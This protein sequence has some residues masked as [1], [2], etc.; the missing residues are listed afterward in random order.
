MRRG[1][2]MAPRMPAAARWGRWADQLRGRH[3]RV[4]GRYRRLALVLLSRIAP[5]QVTIDRR[6]D[7]LQ[8]GPRIE[9]AIGLF[10]KPESTGQVTGRRGLPT[11]LV[12]PARSRGAHAVARKS[13]A[14][15]EIGDQHSRFEG[16]ARMEASDAMTSTRSPLRRLVRRVQQAADVQDT[17]LRLMPRGGRTLLRSVVRRGRVE[18]P[19]PQLRRRARLLQRLSAAQGPAHHGASTHEAARGSRT[20]SGSVPARLS[21]DVGAGNPPVAQAIQQARGLVTP[22]I[23]VDDLTERVVREIDRRIVAHRERHGRPF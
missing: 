6:R 17:V 4:A 2:A 5:L 23:N 13:A 16:S 19:E 12:L 21:F 22:A 10:L 18:W 7:V 14:A 3:E 20:R 15:R 9:F 11:S 1:R 8:I